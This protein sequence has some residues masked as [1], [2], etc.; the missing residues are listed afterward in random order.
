ME[1]LAQGV[2]AA[3]KESGLTVATCES[4][5]GGMIASTL[6]DVPGASQVV[7]GGL[8]TY[9]T[10]TKT[11]LAGVPAALIAEKGVVSAEVARAMAE[12]ARAKLQSDIAVSATGMASPGTKDEPPAGM[13]FVGVSSGRASRAIPLH[14]QGDRASIR[15][16][17]VEAALRAILREANDWR[18]AT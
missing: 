10:D 1:T 17:S 13:V 3:L 8:V 11:L 12:G 14:L 2:I 5:T 7:R 15:R 18:E 6:V 4:L 9:Q 16:Q